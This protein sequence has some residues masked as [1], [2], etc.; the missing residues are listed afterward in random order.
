MLRSKHLTGDVTFRFKCRC[1]VVM[2]IHINYSYDTDL[3]VNY[4]LEE[5]KLCKKHRKL[6]NLIDQCQDILTEALEE[7]LPNKPLEEMLESED[8]VEINEDFETF[9]NSILIEEEV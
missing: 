7:L 6:Q 9:F 2:V 1:E 8:L 4:E 3:I 5:T